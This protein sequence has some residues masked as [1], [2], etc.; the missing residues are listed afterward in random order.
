[1]HRFERKKTMTRKNAGRNTGQISFCFQ[2]NPFRLFYLSN[3]RD[4]HPEARKA[5]K[6]AAFRHAKTDIS[7][8]NSTQKQVRISWKTVLL[9]NRFGKFRKFCKKVGRSSMKS[10]DVFRQKS[11]HFPTEVSASCPFCKPSEWD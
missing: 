11:A 10:A 4:K 9:I 7:D 2:I 5:K 1:M 8:N 6:S 3:E